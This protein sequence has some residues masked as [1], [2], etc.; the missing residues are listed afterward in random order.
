MDKNNWIGNTSNIRIRLFQ[1]PG[2]IKLENK[3][4]NEDI[5]NITRYITSQTNQLIELVTR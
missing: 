3:N 4:K 5:S 2:K 1:N